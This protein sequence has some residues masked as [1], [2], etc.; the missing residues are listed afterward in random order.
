MAIPPRP[1]KHAAALL[2][3]LFYTQD[4]DGMLLVSDGLVRRCVD[5]NRMM[6]PYMRQELMDALDNWGIQL[7]DLPNL[8]TPG[9]VP[10]E[11][12]HSGY[13]YAL[14]HATRFE[15][16][17]V[18]AWPDWS[19]VPLDENNYDELVKQ[20]KAAQDPFV[21]MAGAAHGDALEALESRYP[22]KPL[23]A[24][25]ITLKVQ[26]YNEDG[27]PQM[28]S[29]W[30]VYRYLKMGRDI[31]DKLETGTDNPKEIERSE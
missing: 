2:A 24:D 10:V 8:D 20:A 23:D 15:G 26:M 14:V 30:P 17:P 28:R 7:V 16:R 31:Y 27:T 13:V 3:Y 19:E 12:G 18:L 4:D 29:G 6:P 25:K 11:D 21:R 5:R 9:G 1:P 22:A